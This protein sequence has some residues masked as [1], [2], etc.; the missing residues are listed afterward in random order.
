MTVTSRRAVKGGGSGTRSQRSVSVRLSA[1]SS[2]EVVPQTFP[3]Q[4][5]TATAT[6]T[7]FNTKFLVFDT[8]FL[9][10]NAKFI[11]FTPPKGSAVL[12]SVMLSFH[13]A[14]SVWSGGGASFVMNPC[15][16]HTEFIH[17]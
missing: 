1:L 7:I 17:K 16:K 6:F 3:R 4:G 14:H 10:H 2:W 13:S 5:V 12:Q 11:I 8:Q 9:V 15:P